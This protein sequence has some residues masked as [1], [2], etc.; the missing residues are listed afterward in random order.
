MK[1]NTVLSQNMAEN[2]A[3][4]NVRP[5]IVIRQKTVL[6]SSCAALA[7]LGLP[8]AA[9][10]LGVVLAGPARAQ[11]TLGSSGSTAILGNY[12]SGNPFTINYNT[13]IVT[14]SGD[15]VFGDG[16][17]N[18]TVTN[19]GTVSGGTANGIGLGNGGTISNNLYSSTSTV[20]TI[21]GATDG[22]YIAGAP[23]SVTN[24]GTI[25]GTGNN[26]VELTVGGAVTNAAS[27]TI[28]GG[29]N[30]VA[31]YSGNGTVG[32]YGDISGTDG[33]GVSLNAAYLGNVTVGN[34]GLITGS[35]YGVKLAGG[36]GSLDNNGTI[37]ALINSGTIMQSSTTTGANSDAGVALQGYGIVYNGV[38]NDGLGGTVTNAM[39]LISG[40]TVGISGSLGAQGVVNG[41]TISGSGTAIALSDSGE[42]FNEGSILGGSIGVSIG[43][44]AAVVFNGN[45][46]TLNTGLISGSS[47]G[48]LLNTGS[49]AA[50]HNAAT[51]IGYQN[52]DGTLGGA[53]LSMTGGGM[54]ANYPGGT[55]SGGTLG[56]GISGAPGEVEN[57]GL[58]DG[59]AGTGVALGAGG[60]VLNEGAIYGVTGVSITGGGYVNN[61]GGLIRGGLVGAGFSGF[62]TLANSGT[63]YGGVTGVSMAGGGSVGNGVDGV[64]YGTTTGIGI[65]G[66]S[67]SAAVSNA[68]A[69]TIAGG[70]YGINLATA[71]NLVDNSGPSEAAI[72]ASRSTIAAARFTI[73]PAARSAGN[74]AS[75]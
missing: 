14:G 3:L 51:I 21:I 65:L 30:G 34:G 53:G 67:T 74:M 62:S 8:V 66:T 27:G 39:A 16:S 18:W 6:K 60:A 48:L 63:I 45:Y 10:S 15:G 55:I 11:T 57:A 38:L 25:I 2:T 56:V 26:G 41:G 12:G 22:A 28:A 42:V 47:T 17:Q 35:D 29:S 50:V 75:G 7:L 49:Y 61:S 13:S 73:V 64:I 24:A 44:T 37:N 23:G 9:L 36:T 1:K 33:A 69:G 68:S 31:M 40:D 54:V 59:R 52:I 70:T 43:G 32:N 72:S 71:S 4:L 19:Y 5:N 20:G 58:I 46:G